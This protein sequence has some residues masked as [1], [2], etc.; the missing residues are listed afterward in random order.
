MP[1]F[2][3]IAKIGPQSRRFEVQVINLFNIEIIDVKLL[4][5]LLCQLVIVAAYSKVLFKQTILGRVQGVPT[6]HVYSYG[7]AQMRNQQFVN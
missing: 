6:Q 7:V 3:I 5:G 4:I 1:N 2:H